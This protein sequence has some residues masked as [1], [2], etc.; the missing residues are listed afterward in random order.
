M[1]K[2]TLTGE[3]IHP[4]MQ[5]SRLYLGLCISLTDT[6]CRRILPKEHPGEAALLSYTKRSN[7]AAHASQGSADDG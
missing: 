7:P 5:T 2:D 6:P 1:Y 4:E 3:V